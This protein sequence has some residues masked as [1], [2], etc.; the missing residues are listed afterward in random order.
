[1]NDNTVVAGA[2]DNTE[3]K[4][5]ERIE[6]EV[7]ET[8]EVIGQEVQEKIKEIKDKE[9]VKEQE[10]TMQEVKELNEEY[11][12]SIKELEQ[13]RKEGLAEMQESLQGDKVIIE[14]LEQKCKRLEEELKEKDK[15]ITSLET[16]NTYNKVEIYNSKLNVLTDIFL[17]SNLYGEY[18]IKRKDPNECVICKWETHEECLSGNV[19]DLE[20]IL[21]KI[22]RTNR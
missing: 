3:D 17:L 22:I 20:V 9:F 19:E 16:K 18:Y 2:T 4:E 13:E 5:F 1:M 10:E 21:D 12:K 15:T 14:E 7:Q 11:N 6:K 8:L